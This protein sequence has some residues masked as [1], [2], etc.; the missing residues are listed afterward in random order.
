MATSASLNTPVNRTSRSTSA[1]SAFR[2]RDRNLSPMKGGA[3]DVFDDGGIG[4]AHLLASGRDTRVG[5]Q[6]GIGIDLEN[7][8]LP[9]RVDA[10]IHPR[11]AAE[12]EHF[13]APLRQLFEPAVQSGFARAP[14][15]HPHGVAVFHAGLIP[16]GGVADDSR[17]SLNP[18]VERHLADG[19]HKGRAVPLYERDVEL[20]PIDKALGEPAAAI[21]RS[22]SLRASGHGFPAADNRIVVE[23]ERGIL[24]RRLHN[25]A[26]LADVW[27]MRRLGPCGC[28]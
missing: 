12:P 2:G 16:F 1:T 21:A 17:P 3:D 24:G 25:P 27:P 9:F 10:E 20:A 7:I 11:I 18:F 6:A 26:A 15:E 23:A 5:L 14:I 13:P 19:E 28:W 22:R 4:N 8:G